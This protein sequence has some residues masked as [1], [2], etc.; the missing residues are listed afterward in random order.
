M[1]VQCPYYQGCPL[2]GLVQ[3]E[4]PAFC[5][6]R[7]LRQHRSGVDRLRISW[8]CD[9][10]FIITFKAG[11]GSDLGAEKFFNIKCRIQLGWPDAGVV[12]ATLH[13][14]QS[15]MGRR[16]CKAGTPLPP[17]VDQ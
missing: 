2:T 8:R 14:P 4:A 9:V 3:A 17:E 7:A 16:D 15:C 1:P 6:C 13:C 10:Q 11:F 12:V 5:S